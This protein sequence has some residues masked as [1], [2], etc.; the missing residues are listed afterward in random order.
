MP[1]I[2]LGKGPVAFTLQK[3]SKNFFD[4]IGQVLKSKVKNFQI[5]FGLYQVQWHHFTNY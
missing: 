2:S 5:I 4:K 1:P 3:K